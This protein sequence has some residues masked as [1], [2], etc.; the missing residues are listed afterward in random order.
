MT[1]QHMA[2]YQSQLRQSGDGT[3]T[4]AEEMRAHLA[5]H[6]AQTAALGNWCNP[7]KDPNDLIA[8]L[9]EGMVGAFRQLMT[10]TGQQNIDEH[11]RN[12]ATI[13]ATSKN[14]ANAEEANGGLV[15]QV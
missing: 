14:I 5:D 13:Q 6:N 9:L 12:G 8:G 1:D 2:Y 4:T 15:Q 10:E 7:N 3:T 11:Q